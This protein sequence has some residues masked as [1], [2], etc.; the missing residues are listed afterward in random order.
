MREEQPPD[1]VAL[2]IPILIVKKKHLSVLLFL[3]SVAL[4]VL[5]MPRCGSGTGTKPVADSTKLLWLNHADSVHYVGINTCKQCHMDIY[6]TFIQTGMGQSFAI[7]TKKKSAGK[8]DANAK[9]Y[10]KS[11]DLWYH[12]YW[13]KNDSMY[14]MEYRLNGRDTTYKRVEQVNYIVGSGQHT[15]SHIFSTNGYLQ[16]MPMTYYTQKGEWDLPPGFEKG[17]NSHFTRQIGLECMACHNGLSGFAQG[18]VDKYTSVAVGIDCERCHGPGSLHVQQKQTGHLI[19]T[20][21]YADHTIVNPAKLSPDRQFDVCQRCHLQGNAVWKDG[22]TPYD[23]RPGMVLSDY[24]TVFMPHYTDDKDQFIMASHADR[25]KMSKCYLQSLNR[26]VT[27]SLHPYKDAMTCV[28]CHNPHVSVKATGDSTFNNACTNCHN[29]ATT[30]STLKQCSDTPAHLLAAQNNCVSCHMP[31]S[32][33][34]DIPHVSVHDHYIR[35]PGDIKAQADA[36]KA[37]VGLYAV[38]EK[39]PSPEVLAKAYIQQYDKFDP[40]KTFLLDSAKKLLPDSTPD[41]IRAHFTNLIY[42]YYTKKDFTKVT[43]YVNTLSSTAVLGMLNKTSWSND[44]A[45]TAFR[46]GDALASTTSQ[47]A[48]EP[49][50]KKAVDL[51]PLNPDFRCEYASCLAAQNRTAEAKTAYEAVIAQFPKHVRSLSNLG[52]LYLVENNAT[53]AEGLFNQALALEPDD[54]ALQFNRITLF[55]GL[56]KK[57]EALEVVNQ[58]LKRNPNSA[59]AKTVKSYLLQK[60]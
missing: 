6:N 16:Q 27:D 59:K 38:N 36:I 34:I 46:I 25:L 50:L 52:Y 53:K 32:G 15:N 55:D 3:S 40:S 21:K 19:D 29:S 39:N 44:D 43:R 31:R 9:V 1:F 28:T 5:L 11:S 56:G 18:S 13:G 4:A 60:M 57:K 2:P 45:W 22:K 48:A 17:Y 49:F 35:R 47:A 24:V 10:D 51:A 7:A 41:Q 23:F 30:K 42:L 8:F 33:A 12:S 54:E 14:I 20:S 26:P 58:I 37:F